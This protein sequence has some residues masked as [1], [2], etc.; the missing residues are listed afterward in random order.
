MS[1]MGKV[2]LAERDDYEVGGSWEMLC[3]L[4]VVMD[5]QR[6]LL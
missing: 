4:V 1:G 2:V 5:D 3:L 6:D